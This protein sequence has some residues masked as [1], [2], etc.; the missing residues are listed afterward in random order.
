MSS[1]CI[2]ES[3]EQSL[4]IGIL[5]PPPQVATESPATDKEGTSDLKSTFYNKS[6]LQQILDSFEDQMHRLCIW[7][8]DTVGM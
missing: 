4:Y 7:Y 8:G 5:C 3:T 1:T 6:A 2:L